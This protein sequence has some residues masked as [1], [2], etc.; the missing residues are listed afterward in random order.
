[1]KAVRFHEYGDASVLRYED[2]PEPVIGPGEALVRVRAAAVNHVD[3]DMRDGSSRLPI[4]LPHTLGFEVAAAGN[5]AP[6][7]TRSSPSAKPHGHT[8]SS[9]TGSGSARS[10]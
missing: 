7:S 6:P 1:M 4:S 9:S 10:S 5:C 8:G 2:V 3:I